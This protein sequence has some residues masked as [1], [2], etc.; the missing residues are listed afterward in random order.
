MSKNI[1]NS[2]AKNKNSDE[3]AEKDNPYQIIPSRGAKYN[4]YYVTKST[5]TPSV[6]FEI[7]MLTNPSD[8]RALTSEDYINDWSENL[9]SAINQ[10][11]T[12]NNND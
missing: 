7:G 12:A 5:I 11:F 3:D 1:K 4:E 2:F 6:L 10:Y 8:T 9:A